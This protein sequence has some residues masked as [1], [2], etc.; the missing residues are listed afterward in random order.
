MP[1]TDFEKLEA[2]GFD[3]PEQDEP[4]SSVSSTNFPQDEVKE[5]ESDNGRTLLPSIGSSQRMRKM[6]MRKKS[7]HRTNYAF[8]FNLFD[9]SGRP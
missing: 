3:R 6:T 1:E 4:M 9:R 5:Q 7:T 8:D 2:T